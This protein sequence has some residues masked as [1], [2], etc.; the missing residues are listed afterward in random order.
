MNEQN[1]LVIFDCDGVLVDSEIITNRVFAKMINEAGWAISFDACCERFKGRSLPSCL[2]D[3]EARLGR[4]LA[5]NWLDHYYRESNEALRTQVQIIPG[6]KE[7]VSLAQQASW[8]VCIGSS[9][10]ME[11]MEITLGRVGLWDVF[12]GF[13][14]NSAMVENGKPAPDLFLHAARKMKVS[15]MRCIVIEDSSVGARAARH[16]GM[17]CLGYIGGTLNDEKGLVREGAHLIS[18]LREIEGFLTG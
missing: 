3:I 2:V 16:A 17:T 8:Q 7:A 6:A 1:K 5:D 4:T 15:P 12:E 14:F 18:D 13:I 11:K 9:G 10:P